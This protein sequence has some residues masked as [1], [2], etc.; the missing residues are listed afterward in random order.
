MDYFISN[1]PVSEIQKNFNKYLKQLYPLVS[2]ICTQ[3]KTGMH[4]LE[5]HTAAVVF[6][7][8]DYALSL[9]ENPWPVILACAFH[10]MARTNDDFDTEHGKNAVPMAEQIMQKLQIKKQI[11]ES[12]K[13]AIINHTTGIV[14]PD[15]ISACLWDADRTRLAWEY[16]YKPNYFNTLR[17]KQIASSDYNKY[18]KFQ[19]KCFPDL[20][21]QKTY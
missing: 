4:G 2:K 13:F 5:T 1:P 9:K 21:W 7:G 18:I 19:T 10:D 16:G 17:A 6:R 14:A 15:Y 11:Q 20:T 12:V 8:I 3:E